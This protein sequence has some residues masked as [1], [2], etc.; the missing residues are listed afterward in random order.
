[1]YNLYCNVNWINTIISCL[2]RIPRVHIII[3]Y[4]LCFNFLIIVGNF[5]SHQ[6]HFITSVAIGDNSGSTLW[7]FCYSS[8][9]VGPISGL[10]SSIDINNATKY[11]TVFKKIPFANP[12]VGDLRFRKPVPHGPWSSFAYAKPKIRQ[13]DGQK[14]MLNSGYSTCRVTAQQMSWLWQIIW[15]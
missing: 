13:V 10:S 5:S 14:L 9:K 11:H 1:M 3:H 15:V 8:N 2:T 4:Q 12:L 6:N 7:Q